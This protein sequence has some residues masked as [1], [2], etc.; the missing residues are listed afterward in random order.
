MS[1]AANPAREDAEVSS[2]GENPIRVDR[3]SIRVDSALVLRALRECIGFAVAS[4]IISTLYSDA[5]SHLVPRFSISWYCWHP[6]C[7]PKGRKQVSS[8]KDQRRR[9]ANQ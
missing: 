2:K 1:R 4:Q 9:Q 3:V 6:S 5:Y 8:S 7:I